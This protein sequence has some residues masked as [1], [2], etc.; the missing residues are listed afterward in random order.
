[1]SEQVKTLHNKCPDCDRYPRYASAVG[2]WN[3]D[4]VCNCTEGNMLNRDGRRV[5]RIHI[6]RYEDLIGNPPRR[7]TDDPEVADPLPPKD[8]SRLQRL[9]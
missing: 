6:G 5:H 9:L 2:C 4:F 7:D 3:R 1:M 8:E